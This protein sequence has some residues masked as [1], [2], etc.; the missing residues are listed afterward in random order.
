MADLNTLNSTYQLN[1]DPSIIHKVE[2]TYNCMGFALGTYEWEE[3][4]TYGYLVDDEE[5]SEEVKE[6]IM[7]EGIEEIVGCSRI[8]TYATYFEYDD[9]TKTY[10]KLVRK[11]CF[12][13]IRF[14]GIYNKDLQLE[15]VHLEDNEALVLM[16]MGDDDFHFIKKMPDG[17]WYHK[18]GGN[19]IEEICEDEV[20]SDYWEAY[21]ES[22]YGDIAMFII[23]E[24]I[25][26]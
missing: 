1:L 2:S 5:C 9:L 13:E 19:H 4:D 10:N 6:Q 11:Y 18:P 3:F 17:K 15:D 24:D 20:F 16:R 8:D 26:E 23:K 14:I 22:Y 25:A 7:R 21:D 12:P